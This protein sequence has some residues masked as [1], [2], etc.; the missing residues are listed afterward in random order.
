ML[1]AKLEAAEEDIWIF[2]E[3]YKACNSMKRIL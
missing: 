1:W 2:K 3:E